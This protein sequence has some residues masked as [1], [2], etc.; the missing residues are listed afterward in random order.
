MFGFMGPL[1]YTDCTL[2]RLMR[3]SS[4]GVQGLGFCGFGFNEGI[5][6]TL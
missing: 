2:E 4:V 1:D 3:V 5:D 6:K